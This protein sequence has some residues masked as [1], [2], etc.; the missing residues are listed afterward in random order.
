[1]SRYG[2]PVHKFITK[3]QKREESPVVYKPHSDLQY[4]PISRNGRWKVFAQ[5]SFTIQPR[6]SFTAI[7][8]IGVL[9][10]RGMVFISLKQELKIK[11]C[12]L[13]DGVV[14]ETVDDIIVTIQNNSDVCREYC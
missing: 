8:K 3:Y 14:A 13:Q 11:R 12:S 2:M 9:I 5:T 7:L 10:G 4:P 6:S 1:M